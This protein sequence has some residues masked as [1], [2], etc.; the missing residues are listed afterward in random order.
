MGKLKH[1]FKIHFQSTLNCFFFSFTICW[2]AS[3]SLFAF[4]LI[5]EIVMSLLPLVTVYLGKE[6]IDTLVSVATVNNPVLR[7]LFILIICLFIIELFNIVS[8]KLIEILTG[9]HKDKIN[10]YVNEQ[11]INKCAVLDFSFFDSPQYY[12]NLL[13]VRRDSAS[14]ES[15][16]WSIT[17]VVK[18][19]I[20]LV[21]TGIILSKLSIFF[22]LV[23]ICLNIPA[24][25]IEKRFT[26][27][28][29]NWMYN[30]A[31]ED[32]KLSYIQGILTDK[33]YAK[34]VRLY[35]LFNPFYIQ[36]KAIWKVW[37]TEK[38]S[39]IKRRAFWAIFTS[40]IP[41]AGLLF[42]SLFVI[43]G[44]IKK[45]LTIGDFSYYPGLGA[46][47]IGGV[48]TLINSLSQI[49]DNK[50]RI[51]NYKQFLTWKPKINVNNSNSILL[52]NNNPHIEFRNVFFKYPNTDYYILQN[53]SFNFDTKEKIAFV[54]LNGA[55]KSTI[56]KLLLRFY[57]PTE[58]EI[59]M[60]GKDLREYDLVSLRKIFGVVFQDFSNYAFTVRE[61]IAFSN[62]ENINDEKQME[63]AANM[64]SALGFI[65]NWEKGFDTYL[66]KQ[67]EID[68]REL[69][70][71][72]WQKIAIAR[73]FFKNAP[74]MIFDEPSSNLDPEAEFL[75]FQQFAEL[76][77]DKGAIFISH[78]LSNIV[79]TDKILVLEKGSVIES[80]SHKE[81]INRQGRY[82]Y[83]FNLQAEK[84]KT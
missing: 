80:G 45:H 83:L 39:I 53:L 29:Y 82:A 67:F 40:T 59:L 38:Q 6:V 79:M 36:Y 18:S 49:Y 43:F 1:P 61:N 77:R 48:Y 33:F 54:G 44:I 69:S 42:L 37:F 50:L 46:Q 12:D 51:N 13:N 47:F 70:G 64:S 20:Q 16:V 7:P 84:Y 24:I 17:G 73:A 30:R 5:F 8:Q 19:F 81:L 2:R 11:I 60:D 68:G 3:K 34:E 71:G 27:Y 63:Y 75:V 58:G 56:V 65:K 78:R 25:I 15:M 76:C 9:I 72:E 74:V 57:D 32:R 14:V 41:R 66:T 31:P 26:Q 10:N 62:Y 4:R 35:N 55:G 28:I 52:K 21:A 23:F 22:P